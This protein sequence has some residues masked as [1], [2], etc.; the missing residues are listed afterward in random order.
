MYKIVFKVYFHNWL[1]VHT[2]THTCEYRILTCTYALKKNPISIKH[3]DRAL[4]SSPNLFY[5]C[6][7]RCKMHTHTHGMELECCIKVNDA[8]RAYDCITF[9][10][11]R[12]SWIFFSRRICLAHSHIVRYIEGKNKGTAQSLCAD[13]W[14]HRSS[15]H[16]H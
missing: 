1:I 13:D 3:L 6:A 16:V 5:S 9:A 12:G 2:H 10:M 11:T 8:A 4:S 7:A 14:R 15:S